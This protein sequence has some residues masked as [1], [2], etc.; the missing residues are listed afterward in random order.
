M[1]AKGDD[2]LESVARPLR[3]AARNPAVVK[4]LEA[5][6]LR[7]VA[8]AREKLGEKTARARAL[9]EV[10][11]LADGLDTLG[12]PEK[13]RRIEAILG[14]LEALPKVRAPAAQRT[15]A[16]KESGAS[17]ARLAQKIAAAA[18]RAEPTTA[19]T[20]RR[21]T[22]A[23]ALPG[24]PLAEVVGV[25][26]K[27][28]ERLATKGLETVQD[29]LFFVPRRYED[30]R[31]VPIG[32][33][34]VG[35][36]ATV[37]GQV[38]A[39][40][41]RPVGRG[42]RMLEIALSDGTGT[43]SLR[44]F[45]FHSTL[46]ERY[47]RGTEVEAAG[48]VAAWGA[49]RQ[50]VH[51]ELQR[52]EPDAPIPEP[53]IIPIYPEIEAVPAKT[54]RRIL[55]DLAEATAAKISDPLP[56]ALTRSLELPALPEAVL[57]AHRPQVGDSAQ[58]AMSA[59]RRRLVFDEL[60]YFQLALALT[61][62][63]RAEEPGLVHAPKQPWPEL[64]KAMLPFELTRA[65]AKAVTAIA[66][67]L[68]RESP[69]NR[70]VQGDVGSGKTAV[71]FLAAAIVASAGRQTALLA[72]TEI[73][74]EQHFENG[75]RLLGR[76]G[77]RV[78]LLTGS[79]KAAPRRALLAALAAGEIDVLIGTHAILEPPVVFRDLGLGVVDEQQRFGVEQRAQLRAKR[80]HGVP[81]LLVMTATPIPRT[82]ALTAYGD[83]ALTLIDELPP[84]RTP[85][86]TRVYAQKA[87][88]LAYARVAAALES[89]R[90]AFV[91]F[92]LIEASEKLELAA[93]TEAFGRLQARF[94]PR[95][96]AL[97]HGRL[98]PEEKAEAMAR[99]V[100]GEVAVLV[101]TTVVEVGVDVP[102]ATV[103]VV[104]NA[105]RFGLSQLHQLRG[106]VGRGGHPGLCLLIA[107]EGAEA[108]ARLLVLEETHSGFQVAERDL[109][110]RG[111]GEI[112]GTRQ[113]GLPDLVLADLVRDR[114][115]VELAQQEAVRLMGAD[116]RLEAP[117]HHALRA[118]LLRRFRGRLELARI[119]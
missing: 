8:A 44:F 36:S 102:N 4:G 114:A 46:A 53:E 63:G 115:V 112:L 104:E 1:A 92:P 117:E 100:R 7:G 86:E 33:L 18:P 15:T 78:G 110:I 27:T 98:R 76:L 69:M 29:A 49:A 5:A 30:R 113:S 83:L 82:L 58:A 67:D 65:Q 13:K 35:E 70:L 73:L 57:R 96:A 105:E 64:A 41:V 12:G 56:A 59:M 90:Q 107:G 50:M 39:A 43:L 54:L 118:E 10:E 99:F 24:T 31:W 87:A 45:R 19:P 3:F 17:K 2:P 11:L 95:E 9:A 111:P 32:E 80:T 23:A 93:A 6:V 51:P 60:L 37:R 68:A 89:G 74:A 84:G 62:E 75:K 77:L 21:V 72:P 26:P 106:R 85:V 101:S 25:G 55:Q 103:M 47:G 119:G 116:P 66:A 97:L 22:M 38:L 108:A 14:K 42:R 40:A 79:T 81:D 52:I 61:R 88:E 48:T 94:A 71:A 91:V 34:E 20:G 28:A 16:A 109:E